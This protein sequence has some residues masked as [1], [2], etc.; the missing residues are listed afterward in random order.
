MRFYTVGDGSLFS[1]YTILKNG[2]INGI[3]RGGVIN[4][5]INLTRLQYN[6]IEVLMQL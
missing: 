4:D 1:L 6:I 3:I 5:G 2:D